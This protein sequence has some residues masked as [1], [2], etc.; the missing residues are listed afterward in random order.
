[1]TGWTGVAGERMGLGKMAG[2]GTRHE[3]VGSELDGGQG[4]VREGSEGQSYRLG[5]ACTD[6]PTQEPFQNSEMRHLFLM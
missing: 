3:W 5:L 2:T 6:W 4:L 1:M